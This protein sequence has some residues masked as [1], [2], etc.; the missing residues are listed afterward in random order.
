MLHSPSLS[1]LLAVI[2]QSSVDSSDLEQSEREDSPQPSSPAFATVP[3]PSLAPPPPS[4]GEKEK[5]K[6]KRGSFLFRRRRKKGSRDSLE[7]TD[8]AKSEDLTEFADVLMDPSLVH[9]QTR[10]ASASSDQL[11][12]LPAPIFL[13]RSVSDSQVSPH[14]LYSSVTLCVC[15]RCTRLVWA[16]SSREIHRAIWYRSHWSLATDWQSE[17]AQVSLS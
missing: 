4:S 15:G 6:K 10:A 2:H 17:T 13:S 9:G 14:T 7:P 8:G 3:P 11:L 1:L 16:R 12:S 5:K